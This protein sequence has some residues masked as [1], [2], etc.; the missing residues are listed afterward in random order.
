LKNVTAIAR[1][2]K[3]PLVDQWVFRKRTAGGLNI[4]LHRQAVKA[5]LRT[6]RQ[7]GV[8]GILPD[9]NLYTGG[10]FVDFFGRP[11]ATTPLP[12][13]L[14]DRTDAPVILCHCLR[15]GR[16]FRLTFEAPLRFPEVIDMDRRMVVHT[17]IVA[18]AIEALIRRHPDQWFWLHNRWKRAA[19]APVAV[20]S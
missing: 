3:N 13:L 6:L 7:G 9:Q 11:A 10:V 1:P 12:A 17:Q 14:H 5:G 2:I 15:E 4:I 8:F 20:A 19:E 18:D 16:R